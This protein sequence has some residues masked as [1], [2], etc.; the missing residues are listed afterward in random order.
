MPEYKEEPAKKGPLSREMSPKNET[1]SN[2]RE[3]AVEKPGSGTDSFPVIGI[4][5]SAGGLEALSELFVKMPADTGAAFVVVQHLAPT[6]ESAMPELLERYTRMPV[7]QV[8]DNLEIKPNTIYLI[9]PG[10]NMSIMNGFLQLLDQVE[11]S[12][13]RHP[14]DFFFKSL[15]LDRMAGAVGIILSGTGTDGT[16]GARVIKSELGLV[17]AQDPEEAKYDGMPRSV[18]DAGLTNYVLAVPDIPEQVVTYIRRIPDIVTASPESTDGLEQYLPKI[19]TLIRN[20]T[21]NDFSS[22]KEN[23]LLR[24]IR[25]RMAI[26]QISEAGQ[27]IRFLQQNPKETTVLFKELLINVTS[28]FRDKEAFEVLK[29]VLKEHL[30]QKPRQEEIR[31]WVVGC[32]T[33]EEAYSIAII[34]RESLDELDS[35]AKVQIFGTDLDNEAIDIARNGVYRANIADDVSPEKLKRFFTKQIETYRVNQGIR[36]M[37]VFAT[38]NLI[39]EPPFLK[40]D[41]ITARNLLIYLKSDLQKKIMPLFYYS[42]REN[43]ILFLSPSETVGEFTNL[44]T[45]LDRK[46]KIY[47]TRERANTGTR[48]PPFPLQSVIGAIPPGYRKGDNEIK[49]SD[50]LQVTDRILVSDYAPPYVVIDSAD[51][52]VYVRGDPGKYLKLPE[53][54]TTMNILEMARRGLRGHLSLIIRE[55]RSQQT[56]VRRESVRLDATGTPA[57]EILARPVLVRGQPTEYLMLIFKESILRE[58]SLAEDRADKTRKPEKLSQKDQ[59]ILELEQ[60][61]KRSREDLQATIEEL[62]TSNEEMKSSNEELLS[63]NEELQSTNEELETSREELRSVN[64]ELSTLNSENQERIEQLSR[65]RGDLRNLLNTMSVATLFLDTNLNIKSYTPA[66]TGLFKLRE[67]DLERPLAEIVTNLTYDRLIADAHEV[68][69]TLVPRDKE[70]QSREG[71][72]YLMR[73]LPYR[74]EE[75]AIVGLVITFFDIDERRILQAALSYTRAII[76]TLREPVLV[77]GKDLKVVS[78]NRSFFQT[79]PSSERETTGRNLW[80]LGN[81]QW[82][83]P[84][85]HE[86]LEKILP[87][88]TSFD[89]FPVEHDLPLIGHRKMLLNARRMF[90]ELEGEKILL[91]IED[92]TDRPGVEKLFVAKED[93]GKS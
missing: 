80:E 44:F 35:Q 81:G 38:H 14:I 5:A 29:R 50:I 90:D 59:H 73:I 83:I 26:H 7:H 39:K 15:A 18:I 92:V 76:D 2:P 54:K 9:P 69:H 8:T 79:F 86:L 21:G 84:G 63:S 43:G 53:G 34:L 41:L 62:E 37:V 57:V 70:I 28:F 47:E 13:I 4:G 23:T 64:E 42:L 78:A 6:R 16:E 55:A 25:R 31:V 51:N 65:S 74:T 75:N 85:L 3:S 71:R 67:T 68:L 24:R 1:T 32:A 72:W 60:E 58:N 52:V 87:G 20:E 91:A 66:A 93:Q 82:D 17:I 61:L 77:L 30:E 88:N 89:N 22:Y 27:Y 36:E 10:K 12:G 45:S 46:W 49:Q 56:G 48:T 19:I 33:G 11:P 40:M